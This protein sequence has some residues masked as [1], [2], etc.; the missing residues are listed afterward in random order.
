[1]MSLAF[2]G[3][4]AGCAAVAAPIILH[5][6]K[7]RPTE[8][9][10]FPAFRFLKATAARKRNKNNIRQWIVLIARCLAITALSLA[11]AWPYI[12]E[13]AKRPDSATVILLDHSFSM[14]SKTVAAAAEDRT[15]GI[16]GKADPENPV[17]LGLVEEG[18][19]LWSGGFSGR[20]GDLRAFL[21]AQPKGEGASSI[22]AALKNAD[23]RLTAVPAPKKRII[24]VTDKQAYPWRNFEGRP[25]LS[26]GVELKVDVPAPLPRRDVAI[27]VEPPAEPFVRDGQETRLRTVIEN[28]SNE[29]WPAVCRLYLDGKAMRSKKTTLEPNSTVTLKWKFNPG[30]RAPKRGKIVLEVADDIAADNTAYFA[31]NPA[32]PPKVL[33]VGRPPRGGTDFLA[34]ALSPDPDSKTAEVSILDPRSAADAVDDARLV[35]VRGGVAPDS[36]TGRKILDAVGKNAIGCVVLWDD[37]LETRA[38]LAELGVSAPYAVGRRSLCFGDLDFTHPTLACLEEVKVG[39]LFNVRFNNPPL[40]KPPRVARI[41]A[42]FSDGSPAIFETRRGKG[43]IMVVATKLDR[44]STDWQISPFFLPFWREVLARASRGGGESATVGRPAT[45]PEGLEKVERFENGD[46]KTVAAAEAAR[47]T[48]SGIYRTRS[49]QGTRFFAVNVPPEESN[50]DLLADSL[51]W[52]TAMSKK[53]TPRDGK[54]ELSAFPPFSPEARRKSFW[55]ILLVVALAAAC[56]ELIVANR[57]VL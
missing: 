1:M 44:G 33:I 13:F 24:V 39:G 49:K 46:W 17:M 50:P 12:A 14:T 38:F 32:K 30:K 35:I 10:P 19:V 43:K 56:L 2:A 34:V 40:L 31:L 42:A 8:P 37:S 28:F 23:A 7:R 20:P 57:T 6:L 27:S 36:E 53:K 51:D 15:L 48:E 5:M 9:T 4:L 16:L 3:F 25:I 45:P 54:R 18:S 22:A 52:R 11:F 55:R 26:P 21:K 29:T 47:P 41:V